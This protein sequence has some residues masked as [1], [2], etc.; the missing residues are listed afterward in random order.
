MRFSVTSSISSV[1]LRV[2]ILRERRSTYNLR[3]GFFDMLV[4][5]AIGFSM[6]NS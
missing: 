3:L 4:T 2:G 6:H 1:V 5:V